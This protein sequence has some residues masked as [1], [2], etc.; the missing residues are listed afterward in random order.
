MRSKFKGLQ[1]RFKKS[2]VTRNGCMVLTRNPDGLIEVSGWPRL[3]MLV[4]NVLTL[5]FALFEFHTLWL[6]L[7]ENYLG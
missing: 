7:V 4:S 5:Q 6:E 2:G 1:K 3:R